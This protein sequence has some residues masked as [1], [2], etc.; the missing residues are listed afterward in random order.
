MP[1]CIERR[2]GE[3]SSM[4]EVTLENGYLVLNSE[5]ANYSYG[6]LHTVFLRTFYRYELGKRNISNALIL[7]FGAGSINDILR[8]NYRMNIPV[9]G[10]E[11]DGEVIALYEQYFA[12]ELDTRTKILHTDAK[13]YVAHCPERYS[14]IA[15]DL[16][17]DLETPSGFS[18]KNFLHAAVSLL[19][20]GGILFYNRIPS[21]ETAEAEISEIKNI[22]KVLP[23]RTTESRLELGTMTNIMIV[24]E[25]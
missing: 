24:Y 5:K 3:K 12:D 6:N 16:F 21:N 20:P 18:K 11:V 9:T 22:L 25:N 13:E 23:G 17:I 1:I 2:P 19:A 15:I 10:V 4:L 8:D 14:L 7:G